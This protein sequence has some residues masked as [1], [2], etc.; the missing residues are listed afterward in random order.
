MILSTEILEATANISA[1][2][3]DISRK[4]NTDSDDSIAEKFRNLHGKR[5]LS[6]RRGDGSWNTRRFLFLNGR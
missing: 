2:H 1:Y 5:T 4:D 6:F 3:A